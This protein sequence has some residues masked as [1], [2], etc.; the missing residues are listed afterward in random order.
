[1]IIFWLS[2]FVFIGY[3]QPYDLAD[4][5]IVLTTYET[6]RSELD[7]INL[8]HS[9]RFRYAKR[10][11]STP[12][13]L[14]TINWW[15]ICLDEAQ[16]VESASAKTAQMAHKLYGKHRWCITGT[17]IQR[18]IND[19]YGLLL[20]I[21]EEPFHERLYWETMLYWPYSCGLYFIYSTFNAVFHLVFIFW[22]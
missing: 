12:T 7:F 8:Q 15:R 6:L 5:D 22:I 1:M 21:G 18:S 16:M 2:Y 10:F 20:F 19:I 14:I 13:P 4:N 9:N 3:V 11:N 17:P